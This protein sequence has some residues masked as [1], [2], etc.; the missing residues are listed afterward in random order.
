MAEH[1]LTRTRAYSNTA[2]LDDLHA[3]ITRPGG[4]GAGALAEISE[5]LAR[6]GRPLVAGRDIEAVTTCTPLGWPV[7]R[8][9]S[10]DMAVIVQ[11]APDGPGLRVEITASTRAE[12]DSLVVTLNGQPLTTPR[13]GGPDALRDEEP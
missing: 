12:R 6:T 3:L 10:G 9:W 8:V 5:I 4:P 1:T 11:Q 7:V 2:A 13:T